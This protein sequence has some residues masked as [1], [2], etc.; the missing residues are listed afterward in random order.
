MRL[1]KEGQKGSG[2]PGYRRVDT[3]FVSKE[4][5]RVMARRYIAVSTKL[6]FGDMVLRY[7]KKFRSLISCFLQRYLRFTRD[8]NPYCRC[9]SA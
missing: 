2:D 3:R 4:L 6:P 1:V 8:K 5:K 9:N 7:L